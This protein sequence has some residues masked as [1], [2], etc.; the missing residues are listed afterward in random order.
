MLT[1]TGGVVHLVPIF[2]HGGLARSG[3]VTA[4]G[5]LGVTAVAGRLLAGVML[6]RINARLVGGFA[7][8]LPAFVCLALLAFNGKMET[9]VGIALMLGF[10]TGAELEISTYLSSRH[11]GLRN[12]GVLFGI[13]SGLLSLAT[14]VAPVLAGYAFDVTGSYDVALIVGL[15]LSIGASFMIFSLPDYP[16]EWK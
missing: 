10:C 8:L 12:F 16:T 15:G 4:V 1:I 6:D 14:G 9:A 13:I 5:A 7:F 3:A 11:F 2:T